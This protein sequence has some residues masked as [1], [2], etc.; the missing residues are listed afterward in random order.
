MIQTRVPEGY[1]FP[2]RKTC[3]KQKVLY[4]RFVLRE[5]AVKVEWIEEKDR[6]KVRP[7]RNTDFIMSF[8]API[9][10]THSFF[11]SSL[12]PFPP[13]FLVHGSSSPFLPSPSFLDS[14]EPLPSPP[15]ASTAVLPPGE[16][17]KRR[18]GGG[19]QHRL[20]S[21]TPGT[22]RTTQCPSPKRTPPPSPPV[23]PTHPSPS[24][25]RPPAAAKN[26][27]VRDL[28]GAEPLSPF[29]LANEP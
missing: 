16:E 12:S 3:L 27:N 20:T 6:E 23:F 25:S 13:I 8:L 19:R 24:P 14:F 2:F 28:F 1:L 21:S 17:A 10:P 7:F 11:F 4:A 22:L 18:R 29:A 15:S 26:S 9:P 5:E